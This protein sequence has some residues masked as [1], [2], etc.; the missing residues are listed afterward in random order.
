MLLLAVSLFIF[1]FNSIFAMT[2]HTH[3]QV[4]VILTRKVFGD[5][6]YKLSINLVIVLSLRKY[7]GLNKDY[8]KL[9][10]QEKERHREEIEAPPAEADGPPM[11]VEEVIDPEFDVPDIDVPPCPAP[12][13]NNE[14][15]FDF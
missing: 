6:A 7:L 11:G 15:F 10:D 9:I 14:S 2:S 12:P 4:S 13:P 5:T 1:S 8:Q 3:T